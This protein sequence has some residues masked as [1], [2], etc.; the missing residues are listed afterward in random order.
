MAAIPGGIRP[1]SERATLEAYGDG[2][3]DLV[4][5]WSEWLDLAQEWNIKPWEIPDAPVIWVERW[6]ARR[7]AMRE[8]QKTDEVKWRQQ[9]Q[10]KFR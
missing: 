9:S 1:K 2:Y 3:S 10:S 6:R 4:P 8:R 5:E 7:N